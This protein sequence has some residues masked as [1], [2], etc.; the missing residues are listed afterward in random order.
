[1]EKLLQSGEAIDFMTTLV[2]IALE[3]KE[4]KVSAML[5]ANFKFHLDQEM[6]DFAI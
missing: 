2:K 5:V 6:L 1:M 4:D 3:H